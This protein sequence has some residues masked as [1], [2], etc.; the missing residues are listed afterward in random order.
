MRVCGSV[1]GLQRELC[2]VWYILDNPARDKERAGEVE[3]WCLFWP[4]RCVS[5]FSLYEAVAQSVSLLF[6][7]ESS[8]ADYYFVYCLHSHLPVFFQFYYN[9]YF[10]GYLSPSSLIALLYI[11]SAV[12]CAPCKHTFHSV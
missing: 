8:K 1:G 4:P 12:T 11:C 9:C 7:I 5:M 2:M 3:V 10:G 6:L